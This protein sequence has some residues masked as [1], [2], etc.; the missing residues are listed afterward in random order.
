MPINRGAAEEW[1]CALDWKTKPGAR[2]E[3]GQLMR[4]AVQSAEDDLTRARKGF[5]QRL[6]STPGVICTAGESGFASISCEPIV[7][8]PG[9][10]AQT[11]FEALRTR[12]VNPD[13]K[14]L[15][16][17]IEVF[18]TARQLAMGFHY[19]LH[20]TPP[21]QWIFSRGLWAAW[22]RDILSRSHSI[23]TELHARRAVE[24]GKYPDARE[25]LEQWKF[26][27]TQYRGTPQERWHDYTVLEACAAWTQKGDPTLVWTEHTAFGRALARRL[28]VP[29][30]QGGGLLPNGQLVDTLAGKSHVVLSI[31]ANGEGRNLQAWHRNLICSPEPT[32]TLWEQTIGR[33]DRPGQKADEIEVGVI[34]ACTEHERALEQASGGATMA[35]QMLG[36]KQ[37]ILEA[38][39]LP[40][41]HDVKKRQANYAFR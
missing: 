32:H 17:A 27:Q 37:K 12:N 35:N 7:V 8:Y 10:Q 13:G 23:D 39:W 6:T 3:L 19:Y 41:M 20:P 29:F 16:E 5:F 15:V 34:V 18:Q 33:T 21:A 26:W 4:L 2:R 1:A 28:N 30:V 38:D 36:A 14:A 25:A 31:D 40:I 24:D 22:A 11:H 9:P